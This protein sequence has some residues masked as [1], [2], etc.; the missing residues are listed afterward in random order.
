MEAWRPSIEP[1]ICSHI[2]QS[3]NLMLLGC[4][5]WTKIVHFSIRRIELF[6]DHGK[7][8]STRW[9]PH[10]CCGEWLA[11]GIVVWAGGIM[12]IGRQQVRRTRLMRFLGQLTDFVFIDRFSWRLDFP[13]FENFIHGGNNHFLGCIER[14]PLWEQIEPCS[15]LE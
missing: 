8:L 2:V 9:S 6:F 13:F 14:N 5:N 10:S 3:T 1:G 15:W 4:I 7:T 12:R 11:L